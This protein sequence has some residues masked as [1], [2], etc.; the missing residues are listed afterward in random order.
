MLPWISPPRPQTLRAL[1]EQ[2]LVLH[3]LSPQHGVELAQENSE[4]E[5]LSDFSSLK[6]D[7]VSFYKKIHIE[8]HSG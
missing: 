7:V 2:L 6:W 3:L 8:S 5:L 1:E 4:S